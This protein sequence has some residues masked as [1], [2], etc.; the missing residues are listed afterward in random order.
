MRLLYYSIIVLIYSASVWAQEPADFYQVELV[1]F[2][3]A[4]ADIAIAKLKDISHPKTIHYSQQTPLDLWQTNEY[5]AVQP[6]AASKFLLKDEA[7]KIELSNQYKLLYH[8]AWKQPPY[9][10]AQARYIDILQGP[11]NGLVQGVAW[12]S[13]ERYFRLR[14]DL[15]YDPH[16]SN[17]P[18]AMEMPQTFLIP[19]HIKKIMSEQKLFYLDHPIVGVLAT[20]RA[21][22]DDAAIEVERLIE[23]S[24]Q[25]SQSTETAPKPETENP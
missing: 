24:T 17:N 23:E 5:S 22:S 3:Q 21:L 25:S 13:Y 4:E 15:Q 2:K 11:A 7:E 10:R 19:I 12:V 8:V 14:L 6:M 16:F 9:H 18:E 20:V 1:I